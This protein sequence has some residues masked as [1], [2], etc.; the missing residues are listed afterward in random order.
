MNRLSQL[1]ENY[2][3]MSDYHKQLIADLSEY[4]VW[5]E[6]R[7]LEKLVDKIASEPSVYEKHIQQRSK[8]KL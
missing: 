3:K 7:D 2:D 1:V 4:L 6:D 8:W 5:Q